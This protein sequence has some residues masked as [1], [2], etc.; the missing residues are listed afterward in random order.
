M[1]NNT[2]NRAYQSRLLKFSL[3]LEGGGEEEKKMI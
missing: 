1:K 2:K 3:F